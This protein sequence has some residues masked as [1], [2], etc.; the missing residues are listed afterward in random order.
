MRPLKKAKERGKS[1]VRTKHGS[2]QRECGWG[3]LSEGSEPQSPSLLA[4]RVRQPPRQAGG[5]CSARRGRQFC[6]LPLALQAK[7][8][9][10]V[11]LVGF[12]SPCQPVALQGHC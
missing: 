11:G 6:R 1:K 10:E 9:A 12:L 3:A 2:H 8:R 5:H 4:S 7:V